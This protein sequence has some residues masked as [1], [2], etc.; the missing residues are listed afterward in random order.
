VRSLNDSTFEGKLREGK[1]VEQ[2]GK[3]GRGVADCIKVFQEK[4]LAVIC[5][6]A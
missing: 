2:S 1:M 4:P 6:F 3:F 5:P